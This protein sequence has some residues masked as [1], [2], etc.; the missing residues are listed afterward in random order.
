MNSDNNGNE[1]PFSDLDNNQFQDI[2]QHSNLQLNDDDI[3]SL[4]HL[5]FNAF[6]NLQSHYNNDNHNNKIQKGEKKESKKQY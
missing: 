1:L 4:N 3:K 2:I 6:L 5:I